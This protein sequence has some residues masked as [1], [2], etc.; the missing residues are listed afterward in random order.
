MEIMGF[1]SINSDNTGFASG[2]VTF[3]IADLRFYS[4]SVA[5]ESF[6][7]RNPTER[8]ARK[9]YSIVSY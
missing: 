4:I 1:Y 8:E 5:V 6:V 3:K 2:G 9:R 7:L